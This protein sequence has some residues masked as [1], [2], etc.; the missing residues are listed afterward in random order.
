MNLRHI[1]VTDGTRVAVVPINGDAAPGRP[2][3][4]TLVLH[5]ALPE[6]TVSCHKLSW[7]F[8]GH[9]GFQKSRR[10][11]ETSATASHYALDTDPSRRSRKL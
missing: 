4:N 1:V 2:F 7:F 10:R 9:F 6:N 5:V 11:V 3:D 8:T